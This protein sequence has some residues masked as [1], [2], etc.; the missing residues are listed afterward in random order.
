MRTFDLDLYARYFGG[1]YVLGRKDLHTDACY[2]VYGL[3]KAGETDRIV[4]PGFGYEEILCAAE[5]ALVVHSEEGEIILPEHHALH[6]RETDSVRL[7][8]P[9]D[10]RAI[11][12]IAGG[13]ATS[14]ADE[15]ARH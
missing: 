1:E 8:N 3:L 14:G 10:K 13:R 11:Y 9:S 5:G 12:I 4:K 2:L 7:S 6:L 15:T